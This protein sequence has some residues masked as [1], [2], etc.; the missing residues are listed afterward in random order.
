MDPIAFKAILGYLYV[1]SLEISFKHSYICLLLCKQCKL[2]SLMKLLEIQR[3]KMEVGDITSELILINLDRSCEVLEIEIQ[4]DFKKLHQTI[5]AQNPYEDI[6]FNVDSV[7][8][9][10]HK[11]FFI[12]RSEYFKA[13]LTGYFQEAAFKFSELPEISLSS[14]S[15]PIFM[16]LT[17]YMYTGDLEI[18][19]DPSLLF[20]MLAIADQFL[21]YN[22]KSKVEKQLCTSINLTDLW[23]FFAAAKLYSLSK[24]VFK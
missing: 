23:D 16:N 20:E 1:G 22:L 19:L 24:L 21:L 5:T 18:I 11:I 8:F 9:H 13:M 15:L 3:N 10:C 17:Q 4:N 2:T 14:L 6:I 7:A 12:E